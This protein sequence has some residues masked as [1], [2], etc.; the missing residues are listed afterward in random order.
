MHLLPLQ[1]VSMAAVMAVA[2]VVTRRMKEILRLVTVLQLHPSH[3]LHPRHTILR[4]LLK[5]HHLTP[6]INR[7]RNNYILLLHLL[8]LL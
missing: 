5:R 4:H 7:N 3:P 2:V 6:F 8:E 1:V